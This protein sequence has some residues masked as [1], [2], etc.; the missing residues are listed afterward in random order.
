[1]SINHN[2]NLTDGRAHHSGS[3]TENKPLEGRGSSPHDELH[4]LQSEGTIF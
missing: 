3:D 1:M 2:K 4:I